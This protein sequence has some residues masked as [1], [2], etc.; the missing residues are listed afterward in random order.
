[1]TTWPEEKPSL[2]LDV[3]QDAFHYKP[4]RAPKAIF[5]RKAIVA[6]EMKF[7]SLERV[8]NGAGEVFSKGRSDY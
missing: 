4:T 8:P 5:S 3:F 7:S 6:A 1:M 2:L